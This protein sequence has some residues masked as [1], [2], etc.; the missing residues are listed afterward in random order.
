MKLTNSLVEKFG[1]DK[2][3]HFLVTSWL[4]SEAKYFGTIPM[5]LIFILVI[6][7]GFIKEFIL[8]E[9]FDLHDIIASFLGGLISVILYIL[10]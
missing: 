8:D 3:L 7:L 10:T 6:V 2:L 4:V 9:K 5:I 1:T